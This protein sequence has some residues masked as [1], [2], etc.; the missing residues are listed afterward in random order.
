MRWKGFSSPPDDL[1]RP[2]KRQ[3]LK[4]LTHSRQTWAALL[5]VARSSTHLPQ[6]CSNTSNLLHQTPSIPDEQSVEDV[7]EGTVLFLEGYSQWTISSSVS[8]DLTSKPKTSPRQRINIGGANPAFCNI[9]DEFFPE[10]VGFEPVPTCASRGNYIFA[11]VLGWSYI[12]ST[13]LI[14]LR[15]RAEED[16]VIYTDKRAA[17]HC[18]GSALPCEGF[19]IPIGNVDTN[20]RRWWAAIL[21]GGCGW[22]A[23]L[24]RSGN[25]YC[26]PWACHLNQRERF[27]IRYE[28]TPHL[29]PDVSHPPSSTEAQQY[30]CNFAKLHDAY[31]QLIAAFVASLT[32]PSH[33]RFG[34]PVTLPKPKPMTSTE[35]LGSKWSIYTPSADQLPHLMALTCIPNAVL[36]CMSGCFWEPGVHC[37][38]AGEWLH[39]I[40]TEILPP[41]IREKKY[42]VIIGIMSARRPSSAPLWLGSA[43]TGML[44]RIPSILSN[45]MPPSCLEATVWTDC[46]QSF[47][48]PAFHEEL[49]ISHTARLENVIRREDEFRLLYLTDVESESYGTPPLS[50]YPP[51]GLVKLDET[52]IEV[53]L[54]AF[55]GHRLDYS[56]WVWRRQNRPD[57]TDYGKVPPCERLSEIATR[58]IFSW[59]FFSDGVRLDELPMW[60]HEWL[61]FLLDHESDEE[62]A[63]VTSG[64]V[65]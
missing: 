36:S 40:L 56:N 31:D 43:I 9:S 49:P 4:I 50:P 59:T 60:E 2:S 39:P 62:N 35:T 55:C 15:K 3:S 52:A 6:S 25:A 23:T 33:L 54:H 32:I 18:N 5:S 7:V 51:F 38:V 34:A 20:E 17:W 12:L 13:R 45:F 53:R 42:E 63:L 29:S 8:C 14:E 10:W 30:L 41:L 22:Q 28:G 57:L 26:P 61:S 48:D 27:N 11:L 24:N 37:N 64:E 46:R 16:A 1:L 21:A 44:P 19:T 58:N 47:M 65:I